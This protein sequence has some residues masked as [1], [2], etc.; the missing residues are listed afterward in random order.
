LEQIQT[1]RALVVLF[2]SADIW[3]LFAAVMPD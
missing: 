3:P 2:T 1:H